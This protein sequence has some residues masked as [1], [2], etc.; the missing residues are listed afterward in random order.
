MRHAYADLDLATSNS[1]AVF[2]EN[3]GGSVGLSISAAVNRSDLSKKF[4]QI[5]SDIVVSSVH[6]NYPALANIEQSRDVLA[7]IQRNPSLVRLPGFLSD[8]A[9]NVVVNRFSESL[10]LTFKV[11]VIFAILAYLSVLVLR[12]RH[13]IIQL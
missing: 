8:H 9:R 4:S 3:L 6:R 1:L 2:F 7:A 5:P 11:S 13:S 12:H 10:Y